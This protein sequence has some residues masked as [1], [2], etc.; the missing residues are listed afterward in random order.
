MTAPAAAASKPGPYPTP[1]SAPFWD[2][3]RA[4]RLVIQRC[5]RCGARQHYPRVICS[6]CWSE[7]LGWERASGR[8]TVWTLTVAHRPGHPAW[9]ADAP[10]AIAI[11][12]L[13]EGPRLL[14]N[15]VGC[16]PGEVRVGQR[17]RVVF[18]PRDGYTAVQFT[19]ADDLGNMQPAR[20]RFSDPRTDTRG[21]LP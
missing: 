1:V 19:P 5:E 2:A 11:V 13:D 16:A 7:R 14:A 21:G 20:P 3:A 4:G 17:V 18:E 6:A 8:G 12:E 15:I 9:A 10:Y